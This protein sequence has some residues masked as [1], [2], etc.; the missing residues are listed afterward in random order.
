MTLI[1]QHHGFFEK[2]STCLVFNKALGPRN[3]KVNGGQFRRCV[4]LIS[5]SF[6]SAGCFKSMT[7]ILKHMQIL[8]P[9]YKQ[10]FFDVWL[11]RILTPKSMTRILS[12]FPYPY[13]GLSQ[14]VAP[15]IS[16]SPRIH[17]YTKKVPL[18]VEKFELFFANI[19][20]FYVGNGGSGTA[21]VT[22]GKQL[23]FRVV[24][25]DTSSLFGTYVLSYN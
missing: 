25:A 3:I 14:R 7:R 6:L 5:G 2:Q 20:S 1:Q 9:L 18:A 19:F 24:C 16:T 22:S 10:L 11:T 23:W 15:S 13:S 21:S 8:T 4:K 12:F 17:V